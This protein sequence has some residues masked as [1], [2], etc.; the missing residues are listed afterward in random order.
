MIILTAVG[1]GLT[2]KSWTKN[3][4]VVSAILSVFTFAMWILVFYNVIFIYIGLGYSSN[5]SNSFNRITI[6]VLCFINVGSFFL[7][8]FVHL[9]THPLYVLKLVIDQ[10]SY[11]AYQGAYSVTM[12][13]NAFCNVDDVSWGT[14]GSANGGGKKY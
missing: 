5:N 14:K 3:A 6:I 8:L 9:F 13:V 1:G 11:L 2:G 7:I 4:Q 12:V 10:I